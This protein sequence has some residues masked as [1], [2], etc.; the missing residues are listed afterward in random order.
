MFFEEIIFTFDALEGPL[1]I[2]VIKE[3]RFSASTEGRG[4]KHFY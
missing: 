1:K 3:E 2:P 4:D